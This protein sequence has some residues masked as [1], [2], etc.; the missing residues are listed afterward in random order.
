LKQRIEKDLVILFSVL[1]IISYLNDYIWMLYFL[2]PSHSH[3]V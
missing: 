2:G 1:V 3:Q